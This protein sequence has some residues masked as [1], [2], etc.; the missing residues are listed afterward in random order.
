M[1]ILQKIARKIIKLSFDLSVSIIE[2]FSKMEPYKKKVSELRKLEDGTLGKEIAKYLDYNNL[3]LVPQYESHDLK[4]ILLNYQMTAEDE[5]RMQAFMIGNGNYSIPSFAILTFG[6]I[7]LP[8]L[9]A[10]FYSDFQKGKKTIG[11]SEWTIEKYATRNLIELRAE[12]L[13]PELE[14]KTTFDLKR[15]TQIGAYASIAAGTF[16][17]IFCLPFL[18]SSN[19][20][21]LIGAGF[22]FVG[23]AILFIGGLFTLS[24]LSR[25]NQ[26][27][28]ETKRI[29]HFG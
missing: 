19:I 29:I 1:T 20:A 16:G 26:N 2:L 12:L 3:N 11:I 4:H 13:K 14:Q 27:Q 8:D 22:P 15:I 25:S 10:T 7:L 23:G 18:F 6:A 24:N 17:M 21:D 5:I 28:Q 9:W